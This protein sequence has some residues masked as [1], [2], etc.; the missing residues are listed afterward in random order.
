MPKAVE[1]LGRPRE[2]SDSRT[3]DESPQAIFGTKLVLEFNNETD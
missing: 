3:W 1:G 2:R